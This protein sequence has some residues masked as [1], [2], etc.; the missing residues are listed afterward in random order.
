MTD[1][2]TDTNSSTTRGPD[3]GTPELQR[4]GIEV[5]TRSAEGQQ[6][7]QRKDPRHID[8]MHRR[9][10][11]TAEQYAAAKKFMEDAFYAGIEPTT[12]SSINMD[13]TGKGGIAARLDAKDRYYLVEK[14]LKGYERAIVLWVVIDDKPISE[15]SEIR[16]L[17]EMAMDIFKD[18]LDKL[19]VFYGITTKRR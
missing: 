10:S 14:V 5:S 19:A 12:R 1:S 15:S 7:A 3:F 13:V 2:R 4:R 8:T 11:L 6:V 9:G 18:A 16:K 17:Q